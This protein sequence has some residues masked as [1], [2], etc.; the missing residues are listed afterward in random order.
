MLM[1]ASLVFLL[2]VSMVIFVHVS[3]VVVFTVS[4]VIFVSLVVVFI[5]CMVILISL[6]FLCTVDIDLSKYSV[7]Y[8]AGHVMSFPFMLMITVYIHQRP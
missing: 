5:V 2:I 6:V 7:A 3:L 1:F 8:A 4:M